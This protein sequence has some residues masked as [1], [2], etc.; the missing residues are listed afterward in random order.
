VS[1]TT[2]D[3]RTYFPAT[4]TFQ[5][6][7]NRGRTYES[8][9]AYTRDCHPGTGANRCHFTGKARRITAM[10]ASMNP[11]VLGHPDRWQART[12]SC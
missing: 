3:N 4:R 12:R 11:R 9:G 6:E 7:L 2:L 5:Q 8:D 1:R 10:R